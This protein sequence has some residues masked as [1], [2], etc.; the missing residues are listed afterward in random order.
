MA[1]GWLL[2]HPYAALR[3]M[4]RR[5]QETGTIPIRVSPIAARLGQPSL[6]LAA[7]PKQGWSAAT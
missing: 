4:V 6:E 7:T 2:A 1:A 3:S 5:L